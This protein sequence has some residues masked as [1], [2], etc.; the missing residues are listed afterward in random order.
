[1][2]P[3]PAASPPPSSGPDGIEEGKRLIRLGV[4]QGLSLAERLSEQ[5]GRA[6]V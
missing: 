2:S 3:D 4:G 1:M 5:I 6:H